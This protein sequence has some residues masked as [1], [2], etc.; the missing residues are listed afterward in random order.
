MQEYNTLL[1]EISGEKGKLESYLEAIDFSLTLGINRVLFCTIWDNAEE[2][3]KEMFDELQQYCNDKNMRVIPDVSGYY[4]VIYGQPMLTK[5]DAELRVIES[6]SKVVPLKVDE[7]IDVQKNTF[8][9]TK[10][11]RLN[12]K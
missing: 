5:T 6:F 9:K 4:G 10:K 2:K 3:G 7:T 8:V 12:W 1:L 11:E